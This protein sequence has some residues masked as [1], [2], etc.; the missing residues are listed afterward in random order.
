MAFTV[1]LTEPFSRKE[2]QTRQIFFC[3]LKV[4]APSTEIQKLMKLKPKELLLHKKTDI[5]YYVNLL[6]VDACTQI[7]DN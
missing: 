4:P 7:N 1:L 2:P 3:L 6:T 5:R